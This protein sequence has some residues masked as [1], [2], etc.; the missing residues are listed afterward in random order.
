MDRGAW[1]A[2]VHRVAQSRSQLKRLSMHSCIDSI[3]AISFLAHSFIQGLRTELSSA[4]SSV[5]IS[6]QYG[7]PFVKENHIKIIFM[8]LNIF[9]GLL[10]G[11]VV[12]LGFCLSSAALQI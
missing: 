1:W 5:V 10:K 6:L 3:K 4:F 12:F 7:A 2:A 8:V 11:F 9:L